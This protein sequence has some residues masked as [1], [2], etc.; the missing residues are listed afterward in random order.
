M[1]MKEDP[2]IMRRLLP[3]LPRWWWLGGLLLALLPAC[4]LTG[5]AAPPPLPTPTAAFFIPQTA[6]PAAV[7]SGVPEAVVTSAP[8]LATDTPAP[9]PPVE[10]APTPSPTAPPVAALPPLM[11]TAAPT[12]PPDAL[13]TPAPTI[14]PYEGPTSVPTAP[15]SEVPAAPPPEAPTPAPAEAPPA[16]TE[17]LAPPPTEAES[18]PPAAT[19]TTRPRRRPSPTP[20]PLLAAPPSGDPRRVAGDL[21]TVSR[22][23]RGKRQMALTFDA[24]AARGQP[25]EILRVLRERNLHI[26]FFLT[27]KWIEQ[28]PEAARAIAADGH[29][30]ANHSYSHPS[31]FDITD[32]QMIEQL[33]R[34]ELL[35]REVTGQTARPYWRAPYG[36]TNEHVEAVARGHGYRN[37]MWT[38]DSLDSVGK[39]K[40]ADFIYNRVCNSERVDLDGAIILQHIAAP[41]SVEALPRILDTLAERG[42]RVVTLTE[43]LTP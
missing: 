6:V 21:S 13:L 7:P 14:P 43:L 8:V 35:I 42:W 34:A 15:P 18:R 24:G 37:I 20:T 11:P 38:L 25:D 23:L 4:D 16:P 9:A 32:A 28:N 5:P 1:Q 40:T 29:E 39:P 33:D 3:P 41:A 26:T 10:V 17:T 31:F 22:G 2:P 36:A 19:P 27:G 30:I 12:S